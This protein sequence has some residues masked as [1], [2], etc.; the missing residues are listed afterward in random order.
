MISATAL[1][2]IIFL[3]IIFAAFFSGAEMAIL[4]MDPAVLKRLSKDESRASIMVERFFE[5]PH[6]YL[7]ATLL[8]SALSLVAAAAPAALYFISL[9]GRSGP[10][11]AFL[12]IAPLYIF[13]GAILPKVFFHSRANQT[14]LPMLYAL[15]L[16]IYL[17]FPLLVFI[18]GLSRLMQ[19][20]FSPGRE[21]NAF[22]YTRDDLKLL[23]ADHSSRTAMDSESRQMIDRIFEFSETLVEEAMIPLV[24]VEALSEKAT[25]GEALRKIS[26][27]MYSRHPV[28]TDRIDNVIGMVKTVDLLDAADLSSP[29]TPWITEVRYAPYNKP[30]DELLFEM[31]GNNFDFAVVV[32]EYG[33]CIGVITREDIVEE[34]VGEIEDEHDEP[35]ILYRR[36]DQRRVIANA[37]MEIDDIND[38]LGWDLPEGDYETLGGFLLSLFRRVPRKGERIRKKDLIFTIREA[39]PRAVQE[40]MVEEGEDQENS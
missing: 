13:F 26:H 30:V 28:Y 3:S 11:A 32:D 24:E 7:G 8:G 1:I 18:V 34:I 9:Y 20:A 31:Q 4:S 17:F 38:N 29:V 10:L 23:L 14:A 2:L 40:V 16:F 39:S 15:R 36:L 37:R 33:G 25:V 27:H 21:G 35:V 22:W 6:W 19:K 5:R 12:L